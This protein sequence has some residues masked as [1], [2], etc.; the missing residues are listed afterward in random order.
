MLDLAKYSFANAKIRAML[1]SLLDAALFSRFADTSDI[2]EALDIL[3]ATPYKSI[4]EKI[5][6]QSLRLESLER[7]LLAY[8]LAMYRKVRN[9]LSTKHEQY[10]V[11][12]LMQRYELEDLKVALRIWHNKIEVDSTVHILHEPIFYRF[13]FRKIFTAQTIEEIILL[14]DETVYKQPL[15][16]AKDAFK[17]HNAP[18]YLEVALDRDY[19]ERLIA[20][21]KDFSAA[22][23]AI[24][25][26]ILGIEID[27]ENINWL[28]RLRKYYAIGMGDILN[29]VIPGGTHIDKDTV[30]QF[31]TTDG[32]T[33]VVESVAFGSYIKIKDLVEENIYF[34]DQFLYEMLLKEVKRILAGFPFKIGTV[35][36]YLLLKHKETRN[37]VSLL[38]AKLCGMGKEETGRI[39]HI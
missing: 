39:L 14:L 7:E 28:I 20:S 29:L 19:Y 1:S 9:A 23:R 13:D 30:R 32:L 24:A 33:K 3:K 11:S 16:K 26:K 38:Y 17:L 25:R 12:L 37:I 34:I 18:F 36:G 6:R 4:I 5:D 27:A 35:M 10:F 8:D 2:Y 22:D 31:Y 21:T 15:L